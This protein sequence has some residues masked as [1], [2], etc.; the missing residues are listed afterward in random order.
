MLPRFNEILLRRSSDR[1]FPYMVDIALSETMAS[2]AVARLV[3][4][5]GAP[6]QGM[7]GLKCN[8]GPGLWLHTHGLVQHY[9]DGT[10]P[11]HMWLTIS[12]TEPTSEEVAAVLASSNKKMLVISDQRREAITGYICAAFF[13]YVVRWARQAYSSNDQNWPPVI[14]FARVIRNALAHRGIIGLSKQQTSVSWAGLTISH[15]DDGQGIMGENYLRSG[16]LVR[17]MYDVE[18]E[19]R[20]LE[21]PFDL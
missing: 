1:C 17:L 13:D 9:V 10:L 8:R 12:R 5:V 15:A 2:Q 4:A 20:S 3:G 11:H 21:A 18:N 7:V 19:L 16:D 6:D 14:N